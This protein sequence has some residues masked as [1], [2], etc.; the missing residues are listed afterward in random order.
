MTNRNTEFHH[1]P[2]PDA[3][4]SYKVATTYFPTVGIDQQSGAKVVNTK[5]VTTTERDATGNLPTHPG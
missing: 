5:M 3:M 1:D 4:P 2:H